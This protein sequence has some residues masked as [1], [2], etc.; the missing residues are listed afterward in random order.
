MRNEKSSYFL[1]IGGTVVRY[2]AYSWVDGGEII[3]YCQIF[4]FFTHD[5][6]LALTTLAIRMTFLSLDVSSAHESF[7]A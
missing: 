4:A 3:F 5:A 2:I 1:Y 6:S 7:I